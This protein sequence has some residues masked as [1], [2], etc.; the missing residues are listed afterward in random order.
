MQAVCMR[1]CITPRSRMGMISILWAQYSALQLTLARFHL[2]QSSQIT[3][4]CRAYKQEKAQPYAWEKSH[5]QLRPP[6]VSKLGCSQATFVP[7]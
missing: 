1:Q 2:L 7:L 6:F 3:S 4:M 5:L